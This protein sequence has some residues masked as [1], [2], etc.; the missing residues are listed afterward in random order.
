MNK[1]VGKFDI[2]IDIF[3]QI[4]MQIQWNTNQNPRRLV[5]VKI[6]KLTLKFIWKCK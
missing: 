6:D 1:P 3:T 5:S 2:K 4:D